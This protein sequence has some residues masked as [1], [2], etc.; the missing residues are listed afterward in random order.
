MNSKTEK[1]AFLHKLGKE[2]DIHDI[3]EEILPEFGF[4]DVKIT[5]EKGNEP[6]YGKDLV[7][8]KID[9]LED[10]KDWYAFVVK[11]G[12]IKGSSGAIREIE[13]QVSECFKYPYKSLGQTKRIP[14]NKVKVITNEHFSSGAKNKIFESNNDERANIDFW[15][16]EK[17]ITL[18]DKYYPKF[19]IQGSKQYK[20][21]VERIQNR[22][23]SDSIIKSLI[24]DDK[25]AAKL[26]SNIIDPRLNERITNEDGSIKW[27]PRPSNTI[28]SIPNNSI[29]IGEPGSGKSTLFK[30]LSNEIITQ[31]SL[32]NNHEF[33][34]VILTFKEI[35]STGFDLKKAV[36]YFFN[37]E[38]MKDLSIDFQSI[39]NTNSLVVFIDALDELPQV[40]LKEKALNAIGL[41][42]DNHPDIKVI[43]SSRPSDY[44]FHN[45][46]TSG[47]RYL[48]ISDLNRE[49][50]ENFL[51]NYFG[52]NVIKSKSLLKSLKDSEI[53]EKLPKTPM[54]I[55]LITML[56][57]EK[58][59]EIPATIADLYENFVNLLIGKVT[60][61]ETF[62]LIE[63]GAK[64]RILC[65]IAKSFHVQ[66]KRSMQRS[67]VEKLINDY[68]LE[69][70]QKL[71][72]SNIL[73]EILN[74]VGILYINDREEVEF[75]HQSFQEYFTAFEI[76]HHRQTDRK[77]FIGKFNDLWWQ[78]VAIFFAGMSK[79]APQLL[80][81][82]LDNSIPKNLSEYISNTGGIGRLLQA[83]YNTPINNRVKGIERGLKNT[84]EALNLIESGDKEEHKFWQNFSKYG[85][86]QVFGG[87]FKHNNWSIT[88]KEPLSN[89]FDEKI[90]LLDN[91]QLSKTEIFDLEFQLFLSS[92]ILASDD[93][94]DFER[95]ETLV[96]KSKLLNFDLL[97]T[98]DTYYKSLIKHLPKHYKK[99]DQLKT[100][101]RRIRKKIQGIP[102]FEDIVNEPIK[103][104]LIEDNRK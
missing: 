19:W 97:A 64:H 43:C 44:L 23:K 92:A 25:K 45:C 102:T 78:N 89:N 95:L 83:L 38:W 31:N 96:N 29:I 18:I 52:D 40:E 30:T 14:I 63:S 61:Q 72:A 90:R 12:R 47:F 36:E 86:M 51:Y 70:G 56:F 37:K 11:K 60:A 59:V 76:F 67:D 27:V 88:L 34:P 73:D 24:V 54:T 55:A 32:R 82:I 77:L 62:E 3:L 104:R 87:W 74:Q 103:N 33:Y 75:K 5:H 100:I 13:D 91:N 81:D 46:E 4:S 69:R 101:H 71:K 53:L 21:Y 10:K 79:D 9:M 98:L 20:K 16:D 50:V 42:N 1:L 17:L 57:D 15:D 48:E 93:F 41:F 35:A 49:Q 66:L 94:I 58:E 8:S 6:E 80:D 7:C 22:I 26:L 28:V 2:T 84:T 99:D 39:I 85:L 68:S 65:L